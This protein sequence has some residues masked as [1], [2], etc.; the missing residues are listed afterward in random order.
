MRRLDCMG[1][2]GLIDG[3]CPDFD[4]DIGTQANRSHAS[5]KQFMGVVKTDLIHL[6]KIWP[7]VMGGVRLSGKWTGTF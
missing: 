1:P 7:L 6:K 3:V 2:A 4:V 5:T